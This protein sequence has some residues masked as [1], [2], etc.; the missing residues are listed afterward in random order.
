M[1]TLAKGLAVIRAFGAERPRLTLSQ[2]AVAVGL[3]R[4]TARRILLTLTGLGY[5]E[6]DGR[7]FFL[8]PRV[9]ELGFSYLATQSWIDRVLP[10]LQTLSEDVAE[11]CSASVLQGNDIVYVARVQTS[12]IMTS[13]VAVGTHL[14][15]WHTAMGRIML[16]ALADDELRRRLRAARVGSYTPGTITDFGALLERVAEDKARGFSIVDEE[17][18]RGLRSISVI[19]TTRRDRVMGA[20]DVSAHANRTTRNEMRDRFLPRLR[21]IARQMAQSPE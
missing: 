14:T 4:A 3:S 1:A 17:L 19:L 10:L 21:D 12:R 5:V 16:G 18:E 9:M 11:T 6:Q 15:A 7:Q 20:I 8:T 13:A 2:A